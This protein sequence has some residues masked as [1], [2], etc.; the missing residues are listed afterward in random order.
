MEDQKPWPGLALNQEFSQGR[1]LKASSSWAIFSIFLENKAIFM[2][3]DHIS[4][5]SEPFERTRF[6]TF[7]I[8]LRKI[9]LFQSSFYL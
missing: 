8:Q 3:L 6:L 2:P 5:V 7:K 9:K 1:G 4:H